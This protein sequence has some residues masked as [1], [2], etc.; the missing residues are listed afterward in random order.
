MLVQHELPVLNIQ[1]WHALGTLDGPD[2]MAQ[3][4]LLL[5]LEAHD[6]LDDLVTFVAL[7]I[8]LQG[9]LLVHSESSNVALVYAPPLRQ[10]QA[11]Q[12]VGS[13]VVVEEHIEQD[14]RLDPWSERESAAVDVIRVRDPLESGVEMEGISIGP[15]ALCFPGVAQ[16]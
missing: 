14:D 8:D 16:E 5:E 3:S 6:L 10:R 7:Q 2:A 4:P 9:D 12:G 13:C 1:Q 11:T 15:L